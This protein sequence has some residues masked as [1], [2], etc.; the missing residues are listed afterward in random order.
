M[1]FRN[2]DTRKVQTER[3]KSSNQAKLQRVSILTVSLLAY[4]TLAGV[5]RLAALMFLTIDYSEQ[6]N[7]G[8]RKSMV[9]LIS[10]E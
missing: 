6:L 1:L 8:L 7:P 5:T 9:G 4:Q 10:R 3:K 2:G